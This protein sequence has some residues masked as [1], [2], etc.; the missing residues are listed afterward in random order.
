M[1]NETSSYVVIKFMHLFSFLQVLGIFFQ[2]WL[3]TIPSQVF[4]VAPF[5]LM[6]FTLLILSFGQKNA[7]IQRRAEKRKWAAQL[8]RFFSS[9]AP[10]ALGR[11]Y[12]PD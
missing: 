9:L 7:S 2:E 12:R 6:I 8:L 4:Q 1:F 3:P 5:P 10:A 11:P